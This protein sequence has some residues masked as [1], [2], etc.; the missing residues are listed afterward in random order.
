VELPEL[1]GY[2]SYLSSGPPR[3][4]LEQ[5]LALSRAGIVRFLGP[6]ISVRADAG[7]FGARSPAL[8]A[9]MRARTLVEARIPP[10]SPSRARDA[11]VRDLH[12]RGELGEVLLAGR[13]S[14]LVRTVP[15]QQR[16]VA[17]DGT[18]HPARYAI[19]PGV[20]GGVAVH[21]FG[22]PG[23]DAQ[24]FRVGDALARTVLGSL[25]GR[26]G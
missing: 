10:P 7:G 21:G 26:A 17:A 4:R 16:L 13:P 22:K 5:L 8:R 23:V 14:G 15:G 19:G 1:H 20:D 9:T 25:P 2:V 11:L 3:R 24:L 18:P 12:A 6:D